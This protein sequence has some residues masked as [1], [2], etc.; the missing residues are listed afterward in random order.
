MRG[1]AG[2]V[3][4]G[5]LQA[6]TVAVLFGLMPGFSII[7]GAVVALVTLRRGVKDG[8]Q[9]LLWA[10]LPALLLLRLGDPSSAFVLLG[11]LLVSGVLRFTQRWQ[12]ACVVLTGVGLL[13][14]LSLPYQHAFLERMETVFANLLANGFAMQ[15]MVDGEM[16]DLTPQL[17][18]QTYSL[19]YGYYQMLLLLAALVLGR[20][21]QALL[22]NPGGFREEFHSLRFDRRLMGLLLVLIVAGSYGVTPL[23]QWLMMLSLIPLLNG[24]ALIHKV[25]AIRRERSTDKADFSSTGLVVLTYLLLPIAATVYVGLGFADSVIDI[26]KRLAA[27]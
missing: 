18:M 4:A 12:S 19:H 6:A 17:L 8:L 23:N 24:L 16:T 7:S 27:R 15:V 2:Y 13:L 21:W 1:L 14:Q 26:R 25:I 9:V 20:Y 10:L 5:R 3:M 22:Y 11:V